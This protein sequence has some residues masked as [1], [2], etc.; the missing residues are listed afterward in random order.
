MTQSALM[1]ELEAINLVLQSAEEAPVSALVVDGLEPL[2]RAKQCLLEASRGFQ[3][4]GWSFNREED[5][6]LTREVSGEITLADNVLK[7]DVED[8]YSPSIRP[9]QRGSKLY[10][11]ASHRY[12]FERDLK[13]TVV[14]FLPWAELPQPARYVVAVLAARLMQARS[15]VSDR[16]RKYTEED[17]TRAMALFTEAEA[18]EGDYNVLRDSSSVAMT[19]MGY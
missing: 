9:V 13:A 19:L 12:T 5:F 7:V 8:T 14:F 15:S 1:S 17:V 3:S 18:D 11:K 16:T 6:P 10:D 4:S 2:E